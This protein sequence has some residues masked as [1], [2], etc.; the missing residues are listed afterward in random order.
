MQAVGADKTAKAAQ[1][2]QELDTLRNELQARE[3]QLES[4][5][6]SLAEQQTAH[7]EQVQALQARIEGMATTAKKDMSKLQAEVDNANKKMEQLQR[8]EHSSYCAVC[9][10][11]VF[12]IL[13][14]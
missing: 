3:Q 1:A 10:H 12:G 11:L 7:D 14:P 5:Q 2:M 4:S 6:T 8:V 9:L 13:M